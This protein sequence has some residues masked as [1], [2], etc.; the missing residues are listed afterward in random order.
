MCEK[1]AKN[2][3]DENLLNVWI[4]K[5]LGRFNPNLLKKPYDSNPQKPLKFEGISFE[6]RL[7][8]DRKCGFEEKRSKQEFEKLLEILIEKYESRMIVKLIVSFQMREQ[9]D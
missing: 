2:S 1:I 7:N 3:S 6:I 5:K 9:F 8:F 4:T